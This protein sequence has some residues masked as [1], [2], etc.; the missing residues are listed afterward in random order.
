MRAGF[1]FKGGFI[2]V[3]SANAE[4]LIQRPPQAV[5]DFVVG[6]FDRNYPRWSPEV[7]RLD[8]LTPG[9]LQVGSRA[10]QVR[11]DQGRKSESTFYVAAIEAPLRVEFAESTGLF[12]TAYRM[13]AVSTHT[14]LKFTF[15][16]MRI[17]FYMR[18]FEKLIRMSIQEGAQRVVRNI[19]GLAER[20][21]V[22]D[23]TDGVSP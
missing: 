10:R 8:V 22:P 4:I 15:E 13:E 14:R 2:L 18:P 9:T 23:P 12:Q 1:T 7:Q 3:I 11:I 21:L 17:E 6:D 19:K 16:L 20:E 5:F